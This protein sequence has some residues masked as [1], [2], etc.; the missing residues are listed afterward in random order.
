MKFKNYLFLFIAFI[1]TQTPILAQNTLPSPDKYLGYEL[2]TQFTSHHN[3]S[4]YFKLIAEESPLVTY[5]RYGATYEGRELGVVFVSSEQNLARLDEIR[6]NNLK[7][8]GLVEGEPTDNKVV[9]VWLSYNV[10]GDEAS[11][12]E[13]A[14]KTLYELVRPDNSETKQWLQ[15][16]VVVMDPMINPD[17]RDRY[18]H[19]YHETVGE[20][21]NLNIDGAEHHQPWPGGRTNHYHFDLNRDWTWLTQVESRQRIAIYQKWLPQ[22]HVD[23]HE[24]GY[25]E[26]YYF[27]PAAQPFH[28]AITPWQRQFQEVIGENNAKYFDENNWLYFTGEVYDLFYP[29]Y[30]DTYPIFNGAIGMT[31]EQGGGGRAGLAV[32]TADGDTLTLKDRLMHHFTTS[33]STIE[34][35]SN[36]AQELVSHFTEYY[37]R[38]MNN[39]VGQYKSFVIKSDSSDRVRKLLNLLDQHRIRYMRIANAGD[40]EGFNYETG[41]TGDFEVEKGDIVISAY[42]PK[43]VLARVLFEP[44]PVLVD[45]VTYDIT[46]WALPHAYGLNAYATT[47]R[48]TGERFKIQDVD[49]T[50]DN[51]MAG[52]PYA[53]LAEWDNFNDVRF[54]AALLKKDIAVR[55]AMKPFSIDGRSYEAGT[56]LITRNGNGEFGNQLDDWVKQAANKNHVQLYSASTG[57]VSTGSDFGSSSVHLTSDPKVALLSGEGTSSGM[58]GQVWHYFDQQINYPVTIIKTDYFGRVDLHDYDVLILPSG[59]YGGIVSEDGLNKLKDWV[60]AGGKLIAIGGANALLAGK[61]GF[62]LKEKSEAAKDSAKKQDETSYEDRLKVFGQRQRQRASQSNPGSIYEVTMDTTHPLAFGYDGTYSSLKLS[63]DA[64]AFL[65]NGWNV[66]VVKDDAHISGFIGYKAMDEI[67]NTLDFGVQSMGAGTVVYLIDNPLFRAFWYNGK[68]LFGNAVFL[69]GQ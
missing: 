56:L 60:R 9:I 4:G 29:S 41:Q 52:T 39:P 36:H 20:T 31:Y 34:A 66:G 19:W 46:A 24:M 3:V 54:L 32:I 57:L 13:A 58:V 59:F 11:S 55:F 23:F 38:A 2:G 53:Y 10:H 12:S 16:T 64:Y 21:L 25:N 27:A 15:N 47:A 40:Y 51:N 43:S 68:L 28:E 49:D 1:I 17:G 33:L 18:M 45:S 7:R 14:L 42:Q 65:E 5:Q 48:I 6:T 63:T 37:D 62:A 30:G 35:S 8:T 69:V 50:I 44:D 67:K 22:V 26:P 61:K